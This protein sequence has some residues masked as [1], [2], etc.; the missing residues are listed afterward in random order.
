MNFGLKTK[1][2]KRIALV[3]AVIMTFGLFQINEMVT[4][5]YDAQ[6]GMITSLDKSMVET[7]KEPSANAE[8]AS[9]WQNGSPPVN[10]TPASS[11]F[12]SISSRILSKVVSFPP[13]KSQVLGLWQSGQQ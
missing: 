3:L 12:L 10:V 13:S 9:A 2:Q 5:A 8:K 6:T 7:K 1:I 4:F 11:G